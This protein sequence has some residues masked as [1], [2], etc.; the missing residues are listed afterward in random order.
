MRFSL[1]FF[2]SKVTRYTLHV[3]HCKLHVT[4]DTLLLFPFRAF[5]LSCFLL[6]SCAQ[7]VTP[8]GGPKD[9]TPPKM[10]A[11]KPENSATH[12]SEKTIKI[13]FDEFVTLNNPT[14]NVIFSPSLNQPAEFTTKGKSVVVKINDTLQA[15]TTYNIFFAD[16]I[17][18]FHEGN[19]LIGYNYAF[20]TG[21]SIDQHKL[22]GKVIN[23]ETNKPEA[24]VF[25]M[26]YENDIDSLPLTTRPYYL[27][28]T[29]EQG[30]FILQHLKPNN[31]KIF[32]LK[33]IN[34]DLIFNLPN[35]LIAFGD[36]MFQAKNNETDSLQ[37]NDIDDIITL[38]MFQE[39]DTVQ[40]LSPY[41]NP[42]AGIYHFS[43][44]I[45]VHSIEFQIE[46]DPIVDYLSSMS[47][48]QDTLS[49]YL[50][51]FFKDEATIYITTD[52]DRI[53]TVELSPYKT[54]QRAGKNSK[55]A[56]ATLKIDLTNKDHLYSPTLLNFSYPVKPAD[57]VEMLI[58]ATSMTGKDTT[59]IYVNIPTGL[60]LQ[61]PVPFTFEPKINYTLWFKDS[62]FFGYDNTTNDTTTFSFSKKTE[63][64]YGNLILNYK[65]T[66][67][68]SADFI[69]ELL[70]S[71]Q[72]VVFRDIIS[73][74]K[75]VEYN[76]LSPGAYRIKEIED[77]NKNGKWDTGNYRKKVQPEKIFTID[78]EI[79]IRGFWDIE[80]NIELKV[81]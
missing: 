2:I 41:L 24:G 71:N 39:E 74:S 69:V 22:F 25:V 15:N 51:T 73:S 30:E 27:T 53:D 34:S 59:P 52:F 61:L 14:E 47:S 37:I 33:D 13:T 17:Q 19:K 5:V 56:R 79:V 67:K 55:P 36:S 78:K 42:Q 23:A 81:P 63:K 43:F 28:K 57:S 49:I 20:S 70:S 12:F 44:K 35:E 26:L 77:K 60:I 80:E 45:P 46:S 72:K 4:R 8:S 11:E 3:T 32:A 18:D 16:C 10:I 62:L 58:I 76:H 75:T 65:I 40:V 50:K 7:M 6:V 38:R 21:D 31:Y 64:D 48:T 9:V 68:N 66:N 29:D 1:G 54:S